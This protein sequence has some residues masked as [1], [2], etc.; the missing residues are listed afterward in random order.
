MFW[1]GV[2]IAVTAVGNRKQSTC[3]KVPLFLWSKG[4]VKLKKGTPKEL[5]GACLL[6]VIFVL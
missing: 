6:F 1:G 5:R 3:W 4:V 2:D